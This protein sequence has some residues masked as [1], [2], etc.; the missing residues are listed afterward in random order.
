MVFIIC[1]PYLHAE[2][3]VKALGIGKHVVCDNMGLNQQ[4]ALKMVRASQY[5]PAL[6]S[7]VNHSLR[8]LPAFIHMK[9]ALQD[10][11]IGTVS[12]IDV[13]IQMG[14][15]FSNK[16]DWMCDSSMG[17]GALHLIGSHRYIKIRVK[18]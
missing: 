3:S 1:P 13:R 5:Y 9:R 18:K 4:D 7:L 17:G 14:S 8:F 2:I 12:L 16:Y 15:L 11:V 6:I 10:E